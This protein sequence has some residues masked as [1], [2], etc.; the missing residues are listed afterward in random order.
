MKKSVDLQIAKRNDAFSGFTSKVNAQAD[1]FA[2]AF[3]EDSLAEK[4]WE[5]APNLDVNID[6]K[7]AGSILEPYVSDVQG[8][9]TRNNNR[10]NGNG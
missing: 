10:R 9:K 6:G 2:S 5:K 7:K 1:V 4:I 8:Q 3:D